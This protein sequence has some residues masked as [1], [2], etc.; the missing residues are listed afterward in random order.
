MGSKKKLLYI[1]EFPPPYTGVTVKD[2]LVVDEILDGVFEVERFNLYRFKFEKAKA[3]LIALQLLG[4]IKRA[5]R[6]C[7]GVGHPFRTCM[8]FRLARLFHGEAFLDNITVFMMGIGTPGYLRKHPSYVPDVAKGRCVFAE[9]E[10]LVREL[11]DLGCTARYLPNFRKGDHAREPQPVGDVVHF[12]YFAQVRA[13]KGFD[14]LTEAALALNA[15]G[16]QDKFDISVYG[17]VV[18]GYQDEFEHLLASVPN[19]EYKG[20]FDAAKGDVYAE[21]N[22]YDASSSSSSWREGMS[23]SNIECKFAGIANIVSDAGFNPECVH[24]GV[25][26]LLVKP[27]DVDSLTDAMRRVVLDHGLLGRLKRGSFEDR[28]SYDVATWKQEVLDVVRG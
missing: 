18:D 14:T 28:V 9:S 12:V 23:G 2:S 1:G 27:R 16:L 25:D 13:E 24:D 6:I 15:E 26:G 5:E 22:Q 19:M 8:V 10:S 3:P 20:A 7:V 17:N 21:L 11:E 4:A